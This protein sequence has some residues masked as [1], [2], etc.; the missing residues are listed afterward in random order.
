MR[1]TINI[2]DD[3][4]ETARSLAE[5]RRI[6]LGEAVSFLM[7][8]G[9]TARTPRRVKNG[10]YTFVIAPGQERFGPDEVRDALDEPDLGAGS[11]FVNPE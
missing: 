8:R 4:L 10:F 6:S 9:A 7:R 11:V 1:T 2:D 5:A 3:V